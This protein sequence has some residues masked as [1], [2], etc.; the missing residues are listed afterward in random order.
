MTTPGNKESNLKLEGEGSYE[1]A[2]RFQEKQ[3]DFAKKSEVEKM[4]KDA[5]KALDSDEGEALE[6]ARQESAGRRPKAD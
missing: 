1:G 5:A 3:H 4:A 6:K 2:R